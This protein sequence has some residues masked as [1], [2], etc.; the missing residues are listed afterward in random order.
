V[1][2]DKRSDHAQVA[3]AAEVVVG[4][5]DPSAAFAEL[6]RI[7]LR[8]NDLQQVMARVAELAQQAIPAVD[9]ASVTLVS[10]GMPGTVAFTA[11]RAIE[12]D[13]TQYAAG[14][15][16]CLEAAA[17][18]TTL[19]I[20]DTGTEQRW[21]QFAE[22]SHRAGVGST[23]SV[24]LPVHQSLTGALNL[25]STAISAFDDKTLAVAERFAEYAAVAVANA[26]GY[27]STAALAAQL[28]EAMASRAV[29]EQAKGI[30]IAQQGVT[31]DAAFALLAHASQA[32]N[33]KLRD[34]AQA[35]VDGAQR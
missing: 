2:Q 8:A 1:A 17:L 18:R 34:I 31:P 29:I 14:Y 16:P 3:Q 32:G 26:H 19:T 30:L 27:A 11:Q 23:M 22:A 25:Y 5:F 13:E 20:A 10:E 35:I 9:E 28:S 6:A 21:P 7:N 4:S 12:L 15:G 24:G 33:R